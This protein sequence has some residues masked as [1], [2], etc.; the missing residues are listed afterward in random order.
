ME[1]FNVAVSSEVNLGSYRT[2]EEWKLFV[3]MS[4]IVFDIGSYRTYEEWKHNN[5][6]NK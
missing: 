3:I 5:R 1:T 6:R 2:Y 4:E